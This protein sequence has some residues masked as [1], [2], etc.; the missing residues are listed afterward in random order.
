MLHT[1]VVATAGV[2]DSPALDG[3]SEEEEEEEEVDEEE[4]QDLVRYA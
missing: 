3:D 2:V 1:Q 4:T